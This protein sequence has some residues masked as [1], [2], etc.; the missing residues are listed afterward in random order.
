VT[1]EVLSPDRVWGITASYFP[2]ETSVDS[3]LSAS[4]Q[5]LYKEI[6]PGFSLSAQTTR[7]GGSALEAAWVLMEGEWTP[8]AGTY[9]PVLPAGVEGTVWLEGT[10]WHAAMP[11]SS[12]AYRVR[13]LAR[14]LSSA[15]LPLSLRWRQPAGTEGALQPVTHNENVMPPQINRMQASG[16]ESGGDLIEITGLGFFPAGRVSVW[17]AGKRVDW[18]IVQSSPESL[19]LVSPP[20]SGTVAVRIETPQGISN[21]VSYTYVA[22]TAPVQFQTK[23]LLTLP[24]PTQAAWGPDGRLYVATLSGAITALEFGENYTILNTTTISTLQPLKNGRTLGIG[25]SP[26]EPPGAF[27]IYAAHGHLFAGESS[28]GAVPFSGQISG[29]S[30]PGF[31]SI[32]PIVSALPCSN[33]DHGV[34]GLAF[35]NRGS[36]LFSVGGN[37]NA[38]VPAPNLGDVDESPLSASINFARLRDPGFDGQL[39]YV[40]AGT[41][42]PT[43]SA[44]DG[45]QTELSAGRGVGVYVPGL[46]NSFDLVWTTRGQVFATDNGPNVGFGKASLTASTEAGDP[47]AMDKVI[48][49]VRGQYHGHPNRNRGRRDPRQNRYRSLWETASPAVYAPP[50]MEWPSSKNGI[51]EYR[52]TT[53]GGA[54][55]GALLVQHWNSQAAAIRLS[56]DG[57]VVESVLPKVFG[58]FGALDILSGPGGALIG[59]DYSGGEVR[60]SIPVDAAAAGKMVAYDIFPWRAPAGGGHAFVI[61]GAGFADLASTQVLFGAKPAL[62]TSVT[63]TRI[64]GWIP[65]E[66]RPSAAFLPVTVRSGGRSAVIAEA[67]RY[68]LQPGQGTGVWKEEPEWS[69]PG[70]VSAAAEV[71]GL[72]YTVGE[73]GESPFQSFNPATGRW[74]ANLPAPGIPVRGPRLVALPG[75]VAGRGTP[76]GVGRAGGELLLLG[77]P[78]GGGGWLPQVYNPQTAQWRVWEM[79]PVAGA[80]PAAVE[81]GGRVFLCGSGP[82]EA[83]TAAL[84]IFHPT[85]GA[86]TVG[87]PLT[88]ACTE[89][90]VAAFGET[91]AVVGGVPGKSGLV[92]QML[93][94]PTGVWAAPAEWSEADAPNR[95]GASAVAFDQEVYV[96]G[97]RLGNGQVV[98]RVEAFGGSPL[99]L[100]AEEPLPA[101]AWGMG[102][103]PWENTI[104][105]LGGRGQ[106][107]VVRRHWSL[108]R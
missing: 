92:F 48:H 4:V 37:T 106:T 104:S 22:G 60:V 96:F 42:L 12:R 91:L 29:L 100:R 83:A 108:T 52:A 87:A 81:C 79:A 84:R 10:L 72:V 63:P 101:P 80:L 1:L 3:M 97:G 53:F 36:L 59:V 34:N 35:D 86:W 64:K 71:D 75:A 13:C 74:H 30:S 5:P 11:L 19:H 46:R 85:T 39:A 47:A 62:L 76:E 103:V 90:A 25:F 89:A 32:L 94:I 107:Q 95:F 57:R 73:P 51:D 88:W 105:V 65:A 14:V 45:L 70:G 69:L 27:R 98:S 26:W 49:A 2:L 78:E 21:P 17:W 23:T 99:G 16:S 41:G 8:V 24:G 40:H 67:F 44:L 15:A 102:V 31:S 54:L 55:R 50:V 82:G 6:L 68:L 77:Q 61:G 93:T 56:A 66:E 38:G 9:A 20:G 58:T 18:N 33:H 28:G 43:Q 7:L